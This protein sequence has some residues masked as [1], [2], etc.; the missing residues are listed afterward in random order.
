MFSFESISR[1]S[2][3][4]IE[5]MWASKLYLFAMSFEQ[6]KSEKENPK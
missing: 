5:S 4:I 3:K 2:F 6:T 1:L